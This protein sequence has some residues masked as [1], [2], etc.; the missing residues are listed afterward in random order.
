M[1]RIIHKFEYGVVIVLVVLMAVVVLL[2]TLELG[3]IIWKDLTSPPLFL[4]EIDELLDIFGLFMLVLIGIEFL[5]S[6]AK[7]HFSRTTNHAQV[8]VAVAIIAIARKVIITDVKDLPEFALLGM[9]GV[10]LALS[11]SYYLLG[12][13][14]E[15]RYKPG[16]AQ[17]APLPGTAVPTDKSRGSDEK[18]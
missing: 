12:Q 7:T 1:F 13:K 2:A 8:V 11:A 5:Q 3:W 14:G 4:L 6:I 17:K 18:N 10:T 9:A 15:K 16:T